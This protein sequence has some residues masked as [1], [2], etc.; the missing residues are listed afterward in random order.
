MPWS[1]KLECPDCTNVWTVLLMRRT[2]RNPPCPVCSGKPVAQ[3][4]A[5]NV[6]RNAQP[7]TAM[8]IPSNK[9]KA[10]DMAMRVI[11]EDNHGANMRSSIKEG[12]TAAIP[13]PVNPRESAQWGSGPAASY[14]A[15]M[16]MASQDPNRGQG[17]LLDKLADKRVGHM[18]PVDRPAKPA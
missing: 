11:S 10:I 5:P 16:Q 12:E 2:D 6:G 18:R 1:R 13:I 3:L 9:T 14:S 8:E 17:G 4:A 15:A 7:S